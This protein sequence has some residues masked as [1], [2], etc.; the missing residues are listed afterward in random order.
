MEVEE[1]LN[2]KRMTFSEIAERAGISRVTLYNIRQAPENVKL[3]TLKAIC[4]A[5]GYSLIISVERNNGGKKN[6]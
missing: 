1:I 6:G 2:S 3:S 4:S 5:M